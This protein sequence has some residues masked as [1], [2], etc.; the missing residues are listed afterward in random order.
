METNQSHESVRK[1]SDRQKLAILEDYIEELGYEIPYETEDNE[2]ARKDFWLENEA[3]PKEQDKSGYIYFVKEKMNDTVKIG[4]TKNPRT[5]LRLFEVKL[6]FEIEIL[7]KVQVADRHKA[8][9][10]LHKYFDER[11]QNG[12][13]F[14]LDQDDIESIE[15]NEFPVISDLV[16]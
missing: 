1:L 13:W 11:N 16:V 14:A 15:N 5:R 4:K 10:K 9:T 12:E 2:S 8:E 3:T 6:P 7:N